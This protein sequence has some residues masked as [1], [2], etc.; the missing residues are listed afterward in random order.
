MIL[1]ISTSKYLD[2]EKINHKISKVTNS[3]GSMKFFTI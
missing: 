3:P 1:R 2:V